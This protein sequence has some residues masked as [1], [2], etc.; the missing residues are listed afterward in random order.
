TLAATLYAGASPLLLHSEA[1]PAELARFARTFGARAVVSEAW[2]TADLQMVSADSAQLSLDRFPNL[3]WAA[4]DE[5]HPEFNGDWPD[6]PPVPLPP[7]SGTTGKPKVA[8]RPGAA[9][10]AEASNYQQTLQ[11]GANDCILG[12]VP[13]SHA[14]GF[15][16]SVMLPLISGASVVSMRRFN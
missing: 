9:A 10:I 1:P 6:L 3:T 13:M 8:V 14:Y 15:G 5:N 4:V 2:G 12:F 7:T 11:I 16:T